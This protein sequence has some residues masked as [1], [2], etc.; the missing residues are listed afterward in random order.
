MSR[1]TVSFWQRYRYLLNAVL[2][3]LP[4]YYFWQAMNPV[5]QPPLATRALG[6]LSATPVPLDPYAP[7]LHDGVYVKDFRV[8]FCDGCI[9]RIRQAY[10]YAALQPR[11]LD[12]AGDGILHGSQHALHVHASFPRQVSEQDRLWLTLETWD[13]ETFHASWPIDFL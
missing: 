4:V 8:D 9:S 12:D 2:L 10:L 7:Y 6:E 3:A 1:S 5:G 13:G 11:P